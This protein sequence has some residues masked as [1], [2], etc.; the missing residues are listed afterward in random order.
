MI[1]VDKGG[2]RYFE[3]EIFAGKVTQAIFSRRGGVSPTPWASLNMGGTV[4]DDPD[5]V[6]ENKRRALETL[7]VGTTSI[8][9]VWQ[10]HGTKIVKATRPR[11]LQKPHAHADAIITNTIGITLMM[12]FADCVPIFFVDPIR[13]AIGLAHAGWQ[14]TVNGII[15]TTV[16]AM[17][18]AFGSK[19]E[20]IIAGIGP[21]IGPD[22]YQIGE[23]LAGKVR[24]VFGENENSVLSTL[25]G[26]TYFNLWAANQLQLISC[27]IREIE[28]CRI[29][30]A[31]HLDDWY[32]HRAE[33]GKTGRFGA[34]LSLL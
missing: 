19:P 10:V 2:I 34:I 26:N 21:S 3:F 5:N 7:G 17:R 9:D 14:G 22:H 4:G 31:C 23:E 6:K 29:C 11:D 25:N 18:A 1:T 12:R 24:L 16:A 28:V 27:G 30:T 32:S 13:K 33:K 20:D 15:R 8:F